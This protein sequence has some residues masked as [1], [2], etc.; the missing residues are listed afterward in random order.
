M[1]G[2]EG[3]SDISSV[4]SCRSLIFEVQF[5]AHDFAHLEFLDLS[6]DGRRK[7]GDELHVPRHFVM[8][9]IFPAESADVVGRGGLAWTKL[10]PDT[11]FFT[12]FRIRNAEHGG[13]RD[14]GMYEKK[15]FDFARI[16]ILTAAND[17]VFQPSCDLV[18]AVRPT[19]REI[20]RMY[21]PI[22]VDSSGRCFRIFVVT[23]HG[24]VAARA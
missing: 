3:E 12:V 21:P 20:A 11:Q 22:V 1:S 13:L 18:T 5:R 15:F 16:N 4:P 7:F 14:V 6:A 9:N 2:A 17:H 19:D 23:Q 24:A 10:Y 8:R